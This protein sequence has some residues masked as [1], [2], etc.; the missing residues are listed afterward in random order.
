MAGD[1][2]EAI[3]KKW[4][5][6]QRPCSVGQQDRQATDPRPGKQEKMRKAEMI[7]VGPRGLPAMPGRGPA[8]EKE[9]GNEKEGD[10]HLRED[11]LESRGGS[12]NSY[13]PLTRQQ[14]PNPTSTWA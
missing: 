10:S 11:E 13:H 12:I 9:S 4:S 5:R 2:A 8:E 7:Y 6:S 14:A 3:E 1:Q